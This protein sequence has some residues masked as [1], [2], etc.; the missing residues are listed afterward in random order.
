MGHQDRTRQSL[1]NIQSGTIYTIG[2]VLCK[3]SCRSDAVLKRQKSSQ[4]KKNIIKQHSSIDKS[5]ITP[6]INS[7]EQGES[8]ILSLFSPPDLREITCPLSP[9]TLC[10]YIFKANQR[11]IKLKL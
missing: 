2:V 4:H 7:E 9:Q 6:M 3:Y 1:W 5:L 10:N 11:K 8:G